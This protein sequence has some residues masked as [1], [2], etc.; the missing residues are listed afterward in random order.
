MPQYKDDLPLSPAQQAFSN[1]FDKGGNPDYD[2]TQQVQ[3]PK[4]NLTL[5]LSSDVNIR[6]GDS[7]LGG[8]NTGGETVMRRD[9]GLVVAVKADI[10]TP[11]AGPVETKGHK[12][13]QYDTA[14]THLT[15]GHESDSFGMYGKLGAING[16]AL[17]GMYAVVDG[18][19]KVEGMGK[20]RKS[21]ASSAAKTMMGVSGRYDF[22][23]GQVDVG[24]LQLGLQGAAF[25][26]VSTLRQAAGGAAFLTLGQGKFKP[27]LPG[28][29]ASD[30]KG[31]V[32]YA[33]VLAQA[34]AKDITTDALGTNHLQANAVAG[35]SMRFNDHV[36]LSAGVNKPL[37]NPVEGSPHRP[38]AYFSTKLNI[39]F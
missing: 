34:V 38:V 22:E 28:V 9:D 37:T 39:S 3:R 30:V 16:K 14:I 10:T 4:Y 25:G 17:D 26:E 35:V 2:P 7:D 12:G 20:S 18:I 27:D 24:A 23:G 33:G 6:A 19:H 21:P 5:G 1:V 36:A 32:L 13:K 15:V 29:P 31:S 11:A 8:D